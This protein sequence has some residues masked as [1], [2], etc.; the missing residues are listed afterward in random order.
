MLNEI[1]TI[2]IAGAAIALLAACQQAE[3][4]TEVRD[5]V[6]DAQQEAREDNT[7]VQMD[8]YA[9]TAVTRAEGEHKVAIERCE[10]LAGDEQRLCKDQADASLDAAKQAAD[11]PGS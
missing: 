3:S 6:A 4:P 2:L 8:A 7:Q 10:A 11:L 9:D 1:K 5:D